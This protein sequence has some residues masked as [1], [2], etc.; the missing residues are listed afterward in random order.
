LGKHPWEVT[1]RQVLEKIER[2]F[3]GVQTPLFAIGPRGRTDI[4]YLKRAPELFATILGVDLD[5]ELTP[6]VL[7]SVCVQLGVPPDLFGLEMEKPYYP[8]PEVH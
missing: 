5:E 3:G 6:T 4:S 8:D 7:R 1:L 2:D